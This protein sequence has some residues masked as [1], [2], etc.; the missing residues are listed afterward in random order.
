[1]RPL[2]ILALIPARAGSKGILRKNI[3]LLAGKPLI[4][5]TI[6]AAL[7]CPEIDSVV[8]S[9]DDEEIAAI[10]Q[11]WGAKIPFMRPTELARDDTP[12]IAVVLHALDQLPQYDAVIVLQ[13]TSPLRSK[14]DI[15]ACLSMASVR[16]AA[17][18]VSISEPA[19]SPYWMFKLD[20]QGRLNKLLA[21][22]DISR[23][24]DLPPVYALNG[25][26]Y[27]ARKDWL[28]ANRTFLTEETVGYVMPPEKS[29]DIDTPLDW[30]FAEILL[31]G[32]A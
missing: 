21:T 12:S 16:Q 24:Q 1:M 31:S 28:L 7:A 32:I 25:A 27:F 13:P 4:A 17:C 15:E 29:L 14:A 11:H 26:L 3:K 9:T 5:W 20:E 22:P 10:S 6:Q 30:K 2:K 18:V 8:V 19:Q 23:R